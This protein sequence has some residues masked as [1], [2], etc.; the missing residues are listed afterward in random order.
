MKSDPRT[1]YHALNPHP[2]LT[3]V[4]NEK[5]LPAIEE[6]TQNEAAHRQL[7]VQGAL[8]ILLPTE[9]LE[10]AC[11]RTLVA[12]VIAET[13]LGQFIG[14]KVSKSWFMWS[15]ISKAVDIV[16]AYAATESNGRDIETGSNRGRLEKFGLISD[17]RQ[18]TRPALSAF[19]AVLWRVLQYGYIL[20]IGLRLLVQGL[21]TAYS[22]P[23]RSSIAHLASSSPIPKD[24]DA[25]AR[26]P[27][28][29]ILAFR[30]FTLF[31]TVLDL[32]QHMPWLSGVFSL[33]QHQLLF[34]SI[35]FGATDAIL[36]Q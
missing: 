16:K 20:F 22:S 13:I 5:T 26:K 6:Q 36:D 30:S 7:L 24:A 33:L 4:P 2:A 21:F 15:S 32:P 27:M 9:D 29:P 23:P 12:D 17:E 35:H 14:G 34:G 10:N 1:M 19:S 18:A 8:A 28:R 11:L 31:S 3:P 25:A